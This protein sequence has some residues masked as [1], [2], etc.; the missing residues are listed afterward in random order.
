MKKREGTMKLSPWPYIRNNRVRSTVLI[1]SLAVFI[2]LI[3]LLNFLIGAI[4]EPFYK[5]DVEPYS[6]MQLLVPEL[7]IRQDEYTTLEEYRTI[8]WQKL[9]EQCEMVKGTDGIL[10]AKTAARQYVSLQSIVGM[11]YPECWLFEDTSDCEDYMNYMGARLLTGRM[12]QKP[13]E[14]LVDE[15]LMKNNTF[16]GSL[17]ETLGTNYQI[18][19]QVESDYYLAFGITQPAENNLWEIVFVEERNVD[20]KAIYE[21]KGVKVRTIYN[22]PL[23]E[24]DH[25]ISIGDLDTVQT[26]FTVVS[27]VLL[28]IC[29]A[30]VMSLHIMDRHNEWCLLNSIGFST[31]EI[32][33]MALKEMLVCMGIAICVGTVLT[34]GLTVLVNMFLFIPIGFSVHLWRPD[35]IPR[36]IAVMLALIG[37]IQIPIFVGMRRIQTI[38]AIES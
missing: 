7:D 31:S 15:K 2:V 6:K 29:V 38:D 19:G 23:A 20:I 11:T 37:I 36:I 5:C 27:G 10:D 35:A 33:L 17:T 25:Q 24:I 14:I 9:E 13:G 34:F 32:Y 1:I 4:T 28:L 22:Q 18:V 30:V 21:Q 3:Y 8:A 16:S 26:L 12:P